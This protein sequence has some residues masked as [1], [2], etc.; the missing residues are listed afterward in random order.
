MKKIH[1]WQPWW[2]TLVEMLIVI[3]IIGILAA[4]L[5]PRLTGAQGAARDTARYADLN[6]V[7][8]ALTVYSADNSGYPSSWWTFTDT[9]GELVDGWY[10]KS[11]PNDPQL[12]NTVKWVSTTSQPDCQTSHG[13]GQYVYT[14]LGNSNFALASNPETPKK[15]NRVLESTAWSSGDAAQ[16]CLGQNLTLRQVI[17]ATC[18]WPITTNTSVTDTNGPTCTINTNN[19]NGMYIYAN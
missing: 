5:I 17:N 15:S 18:Q 16:W 11:I 14:K 10:I 4:A 9:L 12:G 8:T 3:V 13:W 19:D 2:F 7:G 6:Q 1:P